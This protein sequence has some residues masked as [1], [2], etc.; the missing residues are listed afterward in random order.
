MNPH[1]LEL[2]YHV[3]KSGGVSHA[4]RQ[5]PYGIQQPSVSAQVNALERD[6]GVAL[7][8]RRGNRFL[9]LSNHFFGKLPGFGGE[10]KSTRL[11]SSHGYPSYGGFFLSNKHAP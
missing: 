4:A 7:F 2:F 10:R 8:E 9:N 11:Q 5:M 1:H 6:L 3:A